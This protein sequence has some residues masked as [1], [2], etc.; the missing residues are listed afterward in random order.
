LKNI[1]YIM[2]AILKATLVAAAIVSGAAQAP[3]VAVEVYYES[4]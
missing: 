4:L 3:N 1:N 2:S